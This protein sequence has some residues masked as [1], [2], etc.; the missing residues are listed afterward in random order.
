MLSASDFHQSRLQTKRVTCRHSDRPA[1]PPNWCSHY[2]RYVYTRVTAVYL[3]LVLRLTETTVIEV[4][5]GWPV[6]NAVIYVMTTVRRR[7][8]TVVVADLPQFDQLI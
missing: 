1:R 7:L 5:C 2:S 6:A 4:I 8:F 3:T